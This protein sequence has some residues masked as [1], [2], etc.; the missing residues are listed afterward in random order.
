MLDF[1]RV[2]AKGLVK[3]YGSTLALGGVDLTMERG[4]VTVVEGPNGAGKSTLLGILTLLARP[5]RGTLRFGPYDALERSTELRGSIGVLSHAS[6]A[7]PDLTASENLLLAA[8]L[9]R[10][11]APEKRIAV[12]RD[13]FE[14]GSFGDRPVRTYSRGQLQRVAIARALVHEPRL[15]LLDEPST[16]LDA[17]ST[18]RLVEVVKEEKARGAIIALVTHDAE[19]ANDVADARLAI[20]RGRLAQA[21]A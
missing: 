4:T 8:R 10:V 6:F 14:I 5:T 15:L 20:V 1:E 3:T 16:G 17:H 2:E 13:R 18:R 19:L 12:L 7:Y 11:P 9:Y 21:A